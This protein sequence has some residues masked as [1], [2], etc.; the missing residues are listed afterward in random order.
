M[1]LALDNHIICAYDS[2]AFILQVAEVR[3]FGEEDIQQD[4]YIAVCEWPTDN[5]RIL[6]YG[7]WYVVQRFTLP[8]AIGHSQITFKIVLNTCRTIGH[9]N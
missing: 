9:F 7:Y 3:L 6:V 4:L 8:S 1:C 5:T 2:V